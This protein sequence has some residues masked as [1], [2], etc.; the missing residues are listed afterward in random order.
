MNGGTLMHDFTR[1]VFFF[2][3]LSGATLAQAAPPDAA[4][5][6]WE[7]LRRDVDAARPAGNGA[8]EARRQAIRERARARYNEMDTNRDG[9][10]SRD[11]MTRLHPILAKHFDEID[12][13]GDGLVSEQ[14]IIDALRKRQQMRREGY[15]RR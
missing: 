6:D 9:R 3:I 10:L 2:L 7:R 1:L 8:F 4:G 12:A 11:E 13:N 15:N 14:E 5:P